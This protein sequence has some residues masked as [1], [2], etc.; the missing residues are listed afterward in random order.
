MEGGRMA[1]LYAAM[2]VVAG[3]LLI[4]RTGKRGWVFYALGGLFLLLGAWQAAG[5]AAGAGLSAGTRALVFRCIAGAALA[6]ACAAFFRERRR[7]GE[8]K[9]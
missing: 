5:A 2:W 3:L 4:F 6:V 8:K 7:G 9:P 1:Y